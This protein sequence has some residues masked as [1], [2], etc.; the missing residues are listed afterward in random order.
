[1]VSQDKVMDSFGINEEIKI[2]LEYTVIVNN[3]KLSVSIHLLD[4]TGTC[5]LATAN[6]DSANLGKD[7]FGGKSLK[8]GRYKTS[9][10]IPPNFLNDKHYKISA[11]LVPENM[12][13]MGIAEEVLSFSIIETGEMRKD[14]MG[15]WIGQ[16][17]PKMTWLTD[18]LQYT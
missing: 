18:Y 7:S 12:Y 1:L 2:E 11:F 17:R 5:I 16:I 3:T 6:L 14:Y 13:E 9:C 8:K 10:I 4:S 15:G